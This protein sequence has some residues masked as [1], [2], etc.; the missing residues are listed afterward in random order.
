MYGANYCDNYYASC[1]SQRFG[2]MDLCYHN[3]PRFLRETYCRQLL[4]TRY[5]LM[6]RLV[7]MEII[8]ANPILLFI[9][10][11]MM[12]VM[13][14]TAAIVLSLI[15]ILIFAATQVYTEYVDGHHMITMASYYLVICYH[16][17]PGNDW[18]L[19]I[20]NTAVLVRCGRGASWFWCTRIISLSNAY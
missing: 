13:A 10:L 19:S 1:G 7:R 14:W 18:L 5:C 12:L 4:K 11:I 20:E 16:W 9:I 8:N 17:V 6:L 15:I 3:Q 2:I